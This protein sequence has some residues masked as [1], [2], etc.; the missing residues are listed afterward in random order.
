MSFIQ[1]Q[2]PYFIPPDNMRKPLE[3]PLKLSILK[4]ITHF[5]RPLPHFQVLHHSLIKQPV[6]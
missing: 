6:K 1:D 3:N 5:R 2:F 4:K